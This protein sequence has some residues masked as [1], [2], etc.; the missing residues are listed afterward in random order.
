MEAYIQFK[1]VTKQFGG[2][3]AL[4]DVT[5]D[6]RKGEV[7]C[8]CGENGAGKSTLINI[9]GGVFAPT[10]GEIWID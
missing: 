2:I 3:T 7:H 5:F 8:L 1:G 4:K 9:C 10:R 6:I